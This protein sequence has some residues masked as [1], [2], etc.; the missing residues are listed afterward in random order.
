MSSFKIWICRNRGKSFAAQKQWTQQT[1]MRRMLLTQFIRNDKGDLPPLSWML[2]FPHL[3]QL[4][5]DEIVN[6]QQDCKRNDW[7]QMLMIHH[8]TRIVMILMN[9][10]QFQSNDKLNKIT[11]TYQKVPL[12]ACSSRST[13]AGSVRPHTA[14]GLPVCWTNAA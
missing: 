4:I 6:R 7:D 1:I 3:L 10:V 13:A 2:L 12:T 9:W 11:H 8:Q 5:L 14:T